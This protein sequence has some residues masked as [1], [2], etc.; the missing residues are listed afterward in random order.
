M[1]ESVCSGSM[2]FEP[3]RKGDYTR[4][5]R[6]LILKTSVMRRLKNVGKERATVVVSVWVLV[7]VKLFPVLVLRRGTFS[8]GMMILVSNFMH[9]LLYP[10]NFSPEFRHLVLD[11]PDYINNRL[12]TKYATLYSKRAER[13]TARGDSLGGRVNCKGW[14]RRL[15]GY[16]GYCL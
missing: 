16:D 6:S 4:R 1:C 15:Q 9:F 8:L 3:T 5:R 2:V 13:T 11:G 10:I 7:S 12:W 14:W